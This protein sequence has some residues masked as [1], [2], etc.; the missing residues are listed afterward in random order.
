MPGTYSRILL[1]LVFSTK[2]RAHLIKLELQN[3]LYP[4]MGGIIR[5]EGGTLYQIGGTSNHVHLLIRWCTDES[6]AALLRDLKSQFSGWVH[7]TFPLHQGFAWQE[8]YGVF[9]VSESQADVVSQYIAGQQDHHHVRTF[10]DEFIQL[11]KA[12]KIEYD[13]RYLWD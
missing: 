3:R 13:P 11:L 1:H 12:H 2:K 5:S 4:Y 7:Q 10:E 6:V 8:G 9:S